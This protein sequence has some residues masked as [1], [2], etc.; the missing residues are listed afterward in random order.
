MPIYTKKYILR[1]ICFVITLVLF[2]F[3]ETHNKAYAMPRDEG[4]MLANFIYNLIDHVKWE[5]DQKVL[6]CSY[7]YDKV[8]EALGNID[9][10][11]Y[12]D[13]IRLYDIESVKIKT[14]VTMEKITS[15][16]ILY[17]AKNEL[18]RLPTLLTKTQNQPIITISRIENFSELGGL[19]EFR[20]SRQKVKIKLGEEALSKTSVR[21]SPM[22]LMAVGPEIYKRN[23]SSTNYESQTE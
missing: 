7:G 5:P 14:D 13:A 11:K 2:C 17:F 21:L 16:N 22:I 8:S 3:V 6:I 15:C 19:I 10:S 1:R 18:K 9:V 4:R 12:S 23:Y 20:V